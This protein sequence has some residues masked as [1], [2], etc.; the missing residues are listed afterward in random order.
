MSYSK[1]ICRLF[2][3]CG[4]LIFSGCIVKKSF[5]SHKAINKK[6]IPLF[7]AMPENHLAAHNF[8]T[9]LH[10]SLIKRYQQVGYHI[11]NKGKNNYSLKVVLIKD[12]N[13]TRYISPDVLLF[14]SSLSLEVQATLFDS[15]QKKIES[16]T[17]SLSS[18][19]SKPRNPIMSNSFIFFKLEKRLFSLAIRIE[20]H[21]RNHLLISENRE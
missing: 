14:H 7:I 18:L 21:F 10:R 11:T 4:A 2:F 17:F 1:N 15:N 16:K 8:S 20:Q 19:L 3:I 12:K 13:S 5:V 9:S 6:N